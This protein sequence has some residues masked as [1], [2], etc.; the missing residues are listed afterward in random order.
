MRSLLASRYLLEFGERL[1]L[2]LWETCHIYATCQAYRAEADFQQYR[3]LEEWYKSWSKESNLRSKM[4][5]QA[6]KALLTLTL[7]SCQ[8]CPNERVPHHFTW[9]LDKQLVS[10]FG[11]ELWNT[12]TPMAPWLYA[13]DLLIRWHRMTSYRNMSFLLAFKTLGKLPEPRLCSE[14][15]R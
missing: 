2:V 9:A 5:F 8:R 12:K 10:K 4:C 11:P 13:I 7:N 3:P 15:L 6:S 14:I 1:D